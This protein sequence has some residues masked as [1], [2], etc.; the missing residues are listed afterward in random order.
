MQNIASASYTQSVRKSMLAVV[1]RFS[2]SVKARIYRSPAVTQ[3]ATAP[4]VNLPQ[5]S[6]SLFSAASKRDTMLALVYKSA[7]HLT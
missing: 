2:S 3:A 5:Q 4:Y 6:S 1:R 7:L